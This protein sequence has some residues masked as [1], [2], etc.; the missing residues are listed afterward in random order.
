VWVGKP[1]VGDIP[2][3]LVGS[4]SSDIIYITQLPACPRPLH[5]GSASP[6][7]AHPGAFTLNLI[8]RTSGC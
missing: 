3:L 2:K 1:W 5:F 7:L 6:S 4:E 8:I